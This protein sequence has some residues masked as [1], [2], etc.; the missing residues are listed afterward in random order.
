MP[1]KVY[2]QI[3]FSGGE[4]QNSHND[5]C[6]ISK[7]AA[8]SALKSFVSFSQ[9][10][11]CYLKIMTARDSNGRD[12]FSQDTIDELRDSDLELR[13][14]TVRLA[15]KL[16]NT[17]PCGVNGGR[18]ILFLSK[19]EDEIQQKIVEISKTANKG[20]CILQL[21][22]LAQIAQNGKKACDNALKIVSH[23]DRR[24][25]LLLAY[26][27]RV[28][29]LSIED[30]DVINR[31]IHFAYMTNEK[32]E[33]L[34]NDPAV[35]YFL[36]KKDEQTQ[37]NAIRL[38]NITDSSQKPLFSASMSLLDIASCSRENQDKAVE[39]I[40]KRDKNGVKIFTQNDVSRFVRL[41]DEEQQNASRLLNLTNDSGHSLFSTFDAIKLA[42]ME[43]NIVDIAIRLASIK[44]KDNKN[45]LFDA[46][47]ISSLADKLA[48]IAECKPSAVDDFL[49][50]HKLINVKG[51]TL[52]NDK[53]IFSLISSP[54]VFDFNQINQ[55]YKKHNSLINHIFYFNDI[56]DNTVSVL[57]LKLFGLAD[58]VYSDLDLSTRLEI[59]KELQ[60]IL[61]SDYFTDE[62]LELLQ[63]DSIISG[64]QSSI[65]KTI[66]PT[67]VS[68][69][70][71]VQMFKGF[72]ANNNPELEKL[73]KETDFTIYQKKGLPLVYTR[74]QFLSDFSRV[75]SEMDETSKAKLLNKMQITLVN[76]DAGKLA[77]YN[78]IINL[79][80]LPE[81]THEQKALELAKKFILENK[82]N[83][84]NDK[85]NN[86][87]NSLI[88]GMPEFINIIG[89][90]Q[91]KTQDYSVDIHILTVLNYILNN[92]LYETLSDIEKL[93]IKLSTIVHDISKPQGINDKSH[94]MLSALYARDILTKFNLPCEIKDRVFELVKNH[95]WLE[96]Y[97][98][99]Q[100]DVS[101]IASLFRR[102]G[103]IKIA[104]IMAEAD[105]KAIDKSQSLYNAFKS[106]LDDPMQKPIDEKI[107]FINKTGQM[108]VTSKIVNKSLIPKV[109]YKGETY[110]V[111]DFTKLPKDFDLAQYGFSP[112]T[113]PE[114]LRLLVHMLPDFDLQGINT[115]FD[116]GNPSYE[117]YLCASYIS[118][119]G[120]STYEN[121]KYGVCLDAE[122]VNIA[123]AY[124]ETQLSGRRKNFSKFIGALCA[125]NTYRNFTVNFIKKELGLSDDEYAELFF[126]I[127]NLK[128]ASQFDNLSPFK[129]NDKTIDSKRIKEAILAADEQLIRRNGDLKYNEVNVYTPKTTA[130][131]AKTNS[132]AGV[133]KK[134]LDYSKEHDLPIYILGKD[135]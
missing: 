21:P 78:K 123:N 84:N 52:L 85:L 104:R 11:Y 5:N 74:E 30:D 111:V 64:L 51:E 67:K 99:E 73:L 102:K 9:S 24:G 14:K 40:N 43:N 53:I 134:M 130:L 48:K 45:Y 27:S 47:F 15:N 62:Q 1:S 106:A 19:M 54:A 103:D 118:L 77:G 75:L 34:I 49:N 76:N 108:F 44:A 41:S 63:I 119:D 105:L 94:P 135:I 35:V 42:S 131:I 95:H 87:L 124:F 7:E 65:Q 56:Y 88:K 68:Q 57:I 128:Y 93:C 112:N 92:P 121:K 82:V 133:P 13:L 3:S 97:N 70:D 116:L 26:P 129:I 89:K 17:I 120:K 18:Y 37:E 32:G 38:L 33:K 126:R 110:K 90:L 16:K 12:I 86:A 71:V 2:R 96:L 46:Y 58:I 22:I 107:N 127:Q 55:I 132:L 72:F 125:N 6:S 66:T 10:V 117:G 83:T 8:S 60:A 25:D 79:D 4:F 122:N 36:S 80:F 50:F 23:K 39:L 29:N 98:T 20:D 113:T 91:H 101:Y 81:N 59:I 28:P 115:L 69:A 114:N 31:A 61:D 109:E 100:K